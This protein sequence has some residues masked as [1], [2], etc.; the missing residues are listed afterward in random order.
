MIRFSFDL[1]TKFLI[2]VGIWWLFQTLSLLQ[3][4]ALK[5]IAMVFNL[6][7]GPL[8]F[9]VAMCRTRVAFLFKKYF[10]EDW[11]CFGCFRSEEFINEE[12]E[13]LATIDLLKSRAENNDRR[14]FL[15][16]FLSNGN[17]NNDREISKSLF[18]VGK[19]EPGEIPPPPNPEMPVGRI[20]RLIKSN[21]LTALTNI[22]FGW[23]KETSV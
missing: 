23:R 2:V 8:I 19:R 3:I 9:C 1:F 17:S 16:P 12:C 11:C 10:C 5:Y 14:D 6:L 4:K 21:S 18:N 20:K 13:E 22:N 7:Q 15:E